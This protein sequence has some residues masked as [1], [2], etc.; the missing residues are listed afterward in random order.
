MILLYNF[1]KQYLQKLWFSCF[2]YKWENGQTIVW[3]EQLDF[4][5]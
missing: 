3:F 2:R 5:V 1:K 4:C